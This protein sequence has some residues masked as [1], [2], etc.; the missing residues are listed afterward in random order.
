MVA[1]AILSRVSMLYF[2][3]V[4]LNLPSDVGARIC[5]STPGHAQTPKHGAADAD[6]TAGGKTC[7]G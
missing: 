6:V 1:T 7:H 4:R 3:N 2:S 5:G